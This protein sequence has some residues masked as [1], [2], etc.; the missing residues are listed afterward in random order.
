MSALARLRG[1]RRAAGGPL[2]GMVPAEQIPGTRAEQSAE[3][4]PAGLAAELR[5]RRERLLERYTLTQ[6]ELGGAF[7]EMAV[8]DHVNVEALLSRAAEL[9]RLDAELA[10]LDQIIATGG[11]VAGACPACEAPYARGAAFCWQCGA[12]LAI[13]DTVG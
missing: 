13:A 12:A 7:Y 1:S 4:A 3:P 11:A 5:A 8:R 6:L 10:Q 9:Q 2:P